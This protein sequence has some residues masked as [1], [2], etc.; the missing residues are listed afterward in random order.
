MVSN[1]VVSLEPGEARPAL[2]LTPKSRIVAPLRVVREGPEAFLLITE[3][4]L[5]ETVAS[6]LLRARFAAKCEIELE[7]YRGYL[8]LGAGEGIRN[9]D[10]GIEAFESWDEDER[11]A[12]DP[13]EQL[14]RLRIEAGTPVWGTR[15]R[16]DDPPRRGRA[17]RDARLLHEGLLPGPGADRAAPL[18]RPP[19]PPPAR[20][21]RRAG[22]PRRRDLPRRKGRRPC[23][24]RGRRASRSATSVARSKTMRCSASAVK[25]RGYT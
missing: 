22:K 16:R 9:E 11:E 2:L 10:Y 1:E 21:R 25:T 7:P 12:A 23:D 18:P 6:T 5:A 4:A 8:Q 20:A 17:R 15:A 14:E 13:D 3:A 24:E 19:E